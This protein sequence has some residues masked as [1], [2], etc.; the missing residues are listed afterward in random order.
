MSAMSEASDELEEA[1][2]KLKAV[3][4]TFRMKE[5][6]LDAAE[7]NHRRAE[8]RQPQPKN[9]KLT[10]IVLK[11]PRNMKS[12]TSSDVERCTQMQLTN[13]ALTHNLLPDSP[14]YLNSLAE[15]Q[16]CSQRPD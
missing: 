5:K 11:K 13:A 9:P 1:T 8:G 4:R 16:T 10:P 7:L 6:Q 12:L 3:K 14:R 2:K 15:I